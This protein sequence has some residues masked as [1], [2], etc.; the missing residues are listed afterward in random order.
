MLPYSYFVHFGKD[1]Y[2]YD[3][4]QG[5]FH[6][7]LGALVDLSSYSLVDS[8]E[9]G[10]LTLREGSAGCREPVVVEV[11]VVDAKGDDAGVFTFTMV[12]RQA[13]AKKGCWMTKSLC[14]RAAA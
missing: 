14:K 6:M 2:H 5:G 10:H 1:L 7:Q 12:Q 9:G 4:F 13:G 3:H 8:A 11:R